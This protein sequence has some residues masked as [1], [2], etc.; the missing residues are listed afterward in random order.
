MT[1]RHLGV[2][3]LFYI[4]GGVG[5]TETF[6]RETLRELLPLLPGRC[7]LF[8]N[9]DNDAA[10]RAFLADVPP[11]PGGVAFDLLD[12]SA[13]SRVRRIL[14]EQ[15]ELP[16]R[17]RAAGCDALWSPGYTACLRSPCPQAVTIHDMQ[18]RRFPQ[19]LSPVAWLATHLLVTLGV[20]RCGRVLAVSEFARREIIHFTGCSPDKVVAAPNGVNG[21]YERAVPAVPVPV[22]KPFLLCVAGSYPHKNLPSL[23]R[24][25]DDIADAIPHRLLL[26]GGPGR[27]EADLRKCISSARHRDRIER[28]AGLGPDELHAL[29]AAADLFVLPSLYEGFGLPVAEAELAGALVLSTP[30]ASIPEVGGDAM[31]TYDPEEEGALAKA[32]LSALALDPAERRRRIEAGRAHARSFTWRQTAERTL[33]ALSKCAPQQP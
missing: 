6:L 30:C 19:D 16:R 11:P 10:L 25:F 26:V 2:N 17:V 8:T 4:P 29:Y 12:F 32:I 27:G 24:A 31:L 21:D 5:G 20:R 3:T 28:R 13:T 22:E 14:R 7:T 33:D 18:Y 9:R 1:P 23:V 15:T